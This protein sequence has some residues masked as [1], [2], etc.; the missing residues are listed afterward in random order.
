M[1][2][3]AANILPT[4]PRNAW[5]VVSTSND[6]TPAPLGRRALGTS[7]VLYR[8]ASGQVVCL[9][10]RCAH[11][12]YPLSLGT[13][14]GDLIVSGYSGF[15][16][17]P[18][19]VCVRVPTQPNVPIGARV[20]S[21]PVHDDGVFVWAWL[22]EP[23]SAAFRPPPGI[24]WLA[25]DEWAT[26]GTGWQT[27]AHVSLLHD[28]FGD[29][30]HLA[31]VAPAVAP[32]VLQAAPPPLEVQVTETT[33]SF[34][35][36]YDPARIAPWH[37]AML[38]LPADATHRQRETGEFITPGL[39][40]DGWDV[41]VEGD[42]TPK[43]F[44]FTHAL[45]PIDDHTTG[46]IWRVSRNFDRD[47]ASTSDLARMLTGYYETVKGILETMQRVIDTDGPAPTVSVSADAASL[48]VRKI[49]RRLVA[50]EGR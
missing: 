36:D 27:D 3:V 47:E 25:S 16:Y 46:H 4:V 44:R 28:N 33:V 19:G 43:T 20:R 49:M 41:Y 39:W 34:S 23:S 29:I 40:V 45:T 2:D 14:E 50:D 31:T 37:A 42:P 1:T 17:G 9:A 12:P 22:G 15:A 30:T 35:R 24:P 26:F 7:V 32:P 21:Y 5:Y 11:R 38:G 10:D 8:G 18:D 13:V 48:Q 6:V